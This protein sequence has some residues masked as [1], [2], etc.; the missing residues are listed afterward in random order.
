M[1]EIYINKFYFI[2]SEEN[3]RRI[4]EAYQTLSYRCHGKGYRHEYIKV[5]SRLDLK[6]AINH[7]KNSCQTQQTMPYIHVECHGNESGLKLTSKATIRW[8]DFANQLMAINIA[9]RNNLILSLAT[10]HGG[11]IVNTLL[12]GL[13]PNNK[14]IRTPFFG[15]IRPSSEIKYGEVEPGYED[16]FRVLIEEKDV[17]S[18]YEELKKHLSVSKG[19]ITH[20]CETI[21][22]KL[23]HDYLELFVK[24]SEGEDLLNAKITT[25]KKVFH[26]N[27]GKKFD[28]SKSPLLET[29]VRSDSFYF[30]LF[31]EIRRYY[32]MI[33]LY[34]ENDKRLIKITEIDK[35][36]D[37]FG[38]KES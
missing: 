18:A 21:F 37:V 27:T 38:A 23:V 11:Q 34:P 13:A 17:I 26:D 31:D 5:H 10:C 8:N 29:I 25:L 28:E 20:S 32:F 36:K 15:M 24:S 35:W 2:V 3:D 6:E 30:K 16:F 12:K 1:S 22:E 33:D 19:Y 4:K 9:C 14:K 7:I